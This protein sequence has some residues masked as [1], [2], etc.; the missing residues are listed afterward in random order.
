MQTLCDINVWMFLESFESFVECV[1]P[2]YNDE[3][4]KNGKQPLNEDETINL[5]L[6]LRQEYDGRY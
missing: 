4:I 1:M 3:R 5:F 2:L 6:E